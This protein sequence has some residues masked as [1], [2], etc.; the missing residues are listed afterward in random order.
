MGTKKEASLED[1]LDNVIEN[2]VEEEVD[3][4]LDKKVDAAVG[5][6]I[7]KAKDEALLEI[8]QAVDAAV[9]EAKEAARGEIAN[10]VSVAHDDEE[11]VEKKTDRECKYKN[12]TARNIFTPKG[13]CSPDEVIKLSMADSALCK[14]LKK[15]V[16]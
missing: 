14:G 16:K 2:A 4:V 12:V 1:V 3:E 15:C 13:R 5:V 11:Q 9:I 6:A 7:G 8:S 10:A